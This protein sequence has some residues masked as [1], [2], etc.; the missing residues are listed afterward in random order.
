MANEGKPP[1]WGE[2]LFALIALLLTSG[3]GLQLIFDVDD[4]YRGNPRVQLIYATVD[5]VAIG[6]LFKR[7][8][9]VKSIGRASPLLGCLV[10]YAIASSVWSWAPEVS[11]RR[12]VALLGTTLVAL[13]L[14]ATF[15]RRQIVVLLGTAFAGL[16][17]SSL[18]VGALVPDIGV[19][20]DQWSQGW[21]GLY[22][23]KNGLGRA[24][25]FSMIVWLVLLY[26]GRFPLSRIAVVMSI[27]SLWAL[28]M[29]QSVGAFVV[30][31]CLFGAWGVYRAREVPP[32][33]K[34]AT[35]SV[36]I[37]AVLV[38]IS[39]GGQNFDRLV[40]LLGRDVT[41]TGRVTL[42]STLTS[43][44]VAQ[45]LIGYGYSGFWLGE[46]S[47]ASAV[48]SAV[49]WKPPHAHNGFIDVALDLGA[50]GLLLLL[51]LL[52]RPIRSTVK[53][54]VAGNE[55]ESFFSLGVFVFTI[56]SNLVESSIVS[57][58][59]LYWMILSCEVLWRNSENP[60]PLPVQG[61]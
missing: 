45:P 14:A 21:R 8:S 39:V 27:L 7:W 23:H 51:L 37:P 13:Y 25:A 26:D 40:L 50:I 35:L 55:L 52:W 31:L 61:A 42:W 33:L 54:L 48:W 44:L 34:V 32:L 17:I 30:T 53:S 47:P 16:I 49:G 5:L 41:L 22:V 1:S 38:G 24:A 28:V 18:I 43:D 59:N 12:G 58:N 15:E 9:R 46:S 57:P 10:V 19:Q 60:V 11:L 2:W 3:A 6:L 36:L 20:F 4:I 29:S 56:G